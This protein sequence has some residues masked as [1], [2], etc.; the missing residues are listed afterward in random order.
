MK[1]LLLKSSLAALVALTASQVTPTFAEQI[2]ILTAKGEITLQEIP[3]K[4]AALDVAVID[5][6]DALGIRPVGVLNGLYV[7]YLNHVENS[8]AK[9]IGTFFEPDFETINSLEADLVIVATRSAKYLGQLNEF[10]PAIDLTSEWENFLRSSI[11]AFEQTAKLVGKSEL[12]AKLVTKLQSS[13][14]DLRAQVKDKGTALIIMTNGPKIS[15]FGPGSRF[16]WVHDDLGITAAIQNVEAV[17]HGDAITHEFVLNANPDWLIVVD[18]S[19]AIGREG[20]AAATLDNE[21]IAK[22]TAWQK[23]QVIYVNSATW[24][25]SGN[26]IQAMQATVDELSA[27][28]NK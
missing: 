3:Q 14:V 1:N 26:G 25:I 24:Y 10:V 19:A 20:S 27:A 9:K 21:L 4:I 23:G 28:F 11:G 13:V 15:A 22:T 17:T 6:L 16:G 12:G 5:N 7:D 2:T 8:D 18:R